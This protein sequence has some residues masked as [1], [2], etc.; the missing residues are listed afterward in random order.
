MNLGAESGTMAR[1][2]GHGHADGAPPASFPDELRS[3]PTSVTVSTSYA[4]GLSSSVEGA[5]DVRQFAASVGYGLS[6]D[7]MF[8]LEVGTTSY[9]TNT[10]ST[11]LN[12]PGSAASTAAEPSGGTPVPGKLA[13]PEPTSGSYEASEFDVRRQETAVWGSAFYERKLMTLSSISLTGRAGAGVTQDGV[14]GYGRIVGEWTVSGGLSV[15]VGAEARAMPFRMGA[16]TMQS[17]TSS[18]GTV[19]TAVTGLYMRF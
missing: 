10:T 11:I 13:S 15:V 17:T 12:T 1:G 18:Y 19:L 2:N 8:G 14:L 3:E 5:T 7:D 9:T 16:N 4:A 6:D